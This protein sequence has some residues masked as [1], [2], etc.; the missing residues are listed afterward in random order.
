[1][2]RY[3]S[4]GTKS[5]LIVLITKEYLFM[6]KPKTFRML[7]KEP[8]LLADLSSLLIITSNASIFAMKF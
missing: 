2:Y 7:L 4:D 5:K 1:M 3:E 8:L 6:F